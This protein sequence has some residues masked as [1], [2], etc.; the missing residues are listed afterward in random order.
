MVKMHKVCGKNLCRIT[1]DKNSDRSV[2]ARPA[3]TNV[4]GRRKQRPQARRLRVDFT[5]PFLSFWIFVCCML[6]R[7]LGC[8]FVGSYPTNFCV[9][10]FRVSF[11]FF[12]SFL[13]S[14][15]LCLYYNTNK[16]V[17]QAFFIKFSKIFI[18]NSL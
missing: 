14:P 9:F 13:T 4:R 2:C 5:I 6:S 18:A 16:V 10:C 3:Q 12:L 15:L 7:L 17:C 11:C 1:L 8:E